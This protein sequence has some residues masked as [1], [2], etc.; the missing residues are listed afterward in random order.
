[1]AALSC[2]GRGGREMLLN[3]FEQV[4]IQFVSGV[5][6]DTHLIGP[7]HGDRMLTAHRRVQQPDHRPVRLGDESR[8]R[9]S[10]QWVK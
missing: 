5:I 9:W 4:S 8:R 10:V 1:M 2:Q 6:Y 3:D 7:T